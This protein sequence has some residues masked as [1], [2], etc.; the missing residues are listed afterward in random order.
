MSMRYKKEKND[1]GT[2]FIDTAR[3][4]LFSLKLKRLTGSAVHCVAENWKLELCSSDT[5][6]RYK[7]KTLTTLCVN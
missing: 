2:T 7:C 5:P 1:V 3:K 6:F 4:S